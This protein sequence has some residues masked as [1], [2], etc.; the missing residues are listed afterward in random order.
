[1][2]VDAIVSARLELVSLSP[3]RIEG[4]LGAGQATARAGEERGE[5][6]LVFP[7]GWAE[8]EEWLLR[9]RLDQMRHDPATQPWLLR[10]IVMRDASSRVV[11]HIGFHGP[12]NESGAVEIGYTVFPEHR[13]RGIAIEAVRAM[14]DWALEERGDLRFVASVSPSNA[15]SLALV[16]KLGF[17]VVGRQWDDRDGEELVLEIDPRRTGLRSGS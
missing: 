1:M 7:P 9:Y 6:E 5:R 13:R 11:G 4:L 12:P 16:R 8:Q 10:V 2:R 17:V 14:F 15:P 3:G